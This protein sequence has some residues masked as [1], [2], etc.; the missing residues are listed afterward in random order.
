MIE[1]YHA[2]RTRGYRVIWLAEELGLPYK[3][4]PIS[5]A[6]D[7]RNSEE[8]RRL[9]PTGKVPVMKDGDVVMYESCAMVQYVLAKEGNGRLEPAPGSAEHAMYLSLIHI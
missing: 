3:V 1:I 9:S 5:M 6:P 2:P 8:W 7:F 4:N